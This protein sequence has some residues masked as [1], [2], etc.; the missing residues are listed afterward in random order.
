MLLDLLTK[1]TID[2]QINAINWEEAIR[3]GG[4]LLRKSGAI[5]QGYIDGMI[6]NMKNLGPYIVIAPG[7]AMPHARPEDGVNFLGLSLVTLRNPVS[8][9]N[10]D[11]DP[12]KL[13]FCL[14]ATDE[15]KHVQAMA[16]LVRLL[17]DSR[18][19]KMIENAQTV[20]EVIQVIS[21]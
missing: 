12:V 15:T 2:V 5:E 9:G 14:A 18:K 11:N 16:E 4:L 21:A 17:S 8:F 13:V 6:R 10:K 1:A 3:A 19:I 7:I 20:T